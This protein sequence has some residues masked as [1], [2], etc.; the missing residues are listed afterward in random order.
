MDP[1][2]IRDAVDSDVPKIVEFAMALASEESDQI[3]LDEEVVTRGARGFIENPQFG[4]YLVAEC[5]GQVAGAVMIT[6]EYS[7]WRDGVYWWVQS[8]YVATG[9]RRRGI[10]RALYEEVKARAFRQGNVRGFRLYVAN[11]NRR[12]RK[13]YRNMG[14]RETCYQVMEEPPGPK[15]A[16]V[17][18]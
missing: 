11:H 2:L 1:P 5:S 6:Y 9:F 13:V 3:R 10:Y 12:A 17:P 18:V 16:P 15:D 8:V 4:F 7:D 14:M